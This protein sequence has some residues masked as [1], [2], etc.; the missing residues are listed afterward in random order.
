MKGVLRLRAGSADIGGVRL[1]ARNEEAGFGLIELL[2]SMTILNVGILALIAAFQSGAFAL[3][4]ASKLS[5]AS[6]IADIQMERYRGYKYCGILFSAADV[7]AVDSTYTGDTAAYTG[8]PLTPSNDPKCTSATPP[9]DSKPSL[10]ITGPD[11]KRYRVDVYIAADSVTAAR[12]L[13]RVTVVVRDGRTPT[14][15]WARVASTFDEST[16]V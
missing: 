2:M 14:K 1:R 9:A 10:T 15:V 6:A 4:R 13:K 12:P 8:T 7:A 5:T 16:G 11:S 3:Q